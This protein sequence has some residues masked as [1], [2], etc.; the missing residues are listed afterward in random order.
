MLCRCRRCRTSL[1]WLGGHNARRH[2]TSHRHR[3]DKSLLSRTS[4]THVHRNALRYRFDSVSHC[5][6]CA[7]SVWVWETLRYRRSCTRRYM[8]YSQPASQLT[9]IFN[10]YVCPA[11]QC[12][13]IAVHTKIQ[14]LFVL[15]SGW[16]CP[17]RL[18][19]MFRNVLWASFIFIN[20]LCILFRAR[21]LCVARPSPV[22]RCIFQCSHPMCVCVCCVSVWSVE[23]PFVCL[24]FLCEMIICGTVRYWVRVCVRLCLC[25]DCVMCIEHQQ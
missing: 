24:L 4:Q 15:P 14:L 18:W 11:Q 17:F 23:S 16:N 12:I 5:C 22:A 19:S 25:A 10:I 3:P 8:Q 13:G 20:I 9:I 7:V 21:I 6:R 1:V 2:Q